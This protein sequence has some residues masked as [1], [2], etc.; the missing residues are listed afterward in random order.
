MKRIATAIWQGTGKEGSG[1]LNSKSGVLK[2]TP[3]SAAS[4]FKNEEGTAGTN[5]EE[6]IAAAHAG[7]FN[8]ALSFQLAAADFTPNLLDTTAELSIE[9][10]DGQYE[11]TEIVLILKAKVPNISDEKFQEIAKSAKENCPV[12]KALASIP[13]RLEAQLA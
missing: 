5:P 13:I 3:Y 2:D 1:R 10:K 9:N 11:I 8:M 4:R 6:L 12:S 7:C